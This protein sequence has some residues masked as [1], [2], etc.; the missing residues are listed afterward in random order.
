MSKLSRISALAPFQVRDY[1]RLWCGD[2]LT[3][4]AFEMENIILG[5]YI[6]VETGSV[7][8][9]A[10]YGS[11][12]YL[13]T[14]VSPMFGVMGDRIG[15][16]NLLT[17]MRL[18]YACLAAVIAA[19]GLAGN[20]SPI[21]VLCIVGV[22]GMIRPS[23]LGVRAALVSA[24]VPPAQLM[25]ATSLART[26]VESARITGAIAGAYLVA[27]LGMSHAY[28]AIALFYL[29]GALATQRV[30]PPPPRQI[31]RDAA[32]DVMAHP[33]PWR[34]LKEG[35]VYVWRAPQLLACMLIAFIVNLTAYPMSNGLLPYVAREIYK[36]DQTGLS[37]LVAGFAGGGLI[38]SIA[39]SVMGTRVRAGRMTVVFVLIWYVM[40]LAFSR[41]PTPATGFAVLMVAGACQTLSL[42]SL[43][44]LLLRTSEERYRGRVMGV[45]M[46]AI[47]GLPTGL[48]LSGPLLASQGFVATSTLYV[49]FGT[50]CV[51]R[52]CWRWWRYL[53]PLDAKANG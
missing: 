37:Y 10:L 40:L 32:G 21:V 23:D 18:S 11:L 7:V 3:S 28:I 26:T 53:W 36:I 5:W 30:Q 43:S 20:L 24:I 38:G 6:L 42:V 35:I 31:L 15:H 33:S 17:G 41:M 2:L 34:D 16:R 48:M 45:R 50:A 4:W 52:R 46:L 25:P 27:Q 19:L 39:L 13:G 14:L 47:Y 44:V 9:L 51:L 8:L 12:I 1:R 29:L 49:A 22:I